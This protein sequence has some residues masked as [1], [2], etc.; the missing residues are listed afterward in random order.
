MAKLFQFTNNIDYNDIDNKPKIN[1]VTVEGNKSLADYGIQPA[2]NYAHLNANGKVPLEEID[3]SLLGNLQ[4]QGLWD[5]KTN[6]PELPLNPTINGQYWIVSESGDRFGTDFNVGDWIVA[7]NGVWRKVDNT[8]AV[9][10]VN[11][12]I[13]KVV[14]TS[15]DITHNDTTVSKAIDSEIN[16]AKESELLITSSLNNEIARAEA[17]EEEI[18][19]VLVDHIKDNNNPHNVTKEQIGLGEVDNTSD[20][21]KPISNAV[22]LALNLKADKT[23]VYTK[24][25]SDEK[26]LTE[27]QDISG[28]QDVI[29]DLD[30]IREGAK[31]GETALQSFTE[32]DPTVPEYVKSITQEDITNWNNKS[33]F[34]G[35]YN[36]LTN[37]PIIPDVSNFITKDVDNLTNYTKTSD[38]ATIATSGS[39]NDLS[40]KPYIPEEITESKVSEWGF[41]KNN[42]T[43]TSV[44]MNGKVI[45]SSG[46]VDLGTVITEHQDI[47]GKADKAT[48]LEGYGITNAYTKS[49]V[50]DLIPT[51]DGL[52]TEEYVKNYHDTTKQDKLIAGK[53]ITI[54]NN[55]ISA[56][57][58]SEPSITYTAGD[59]LT[60]SQE[61]EF[62]VNDTIA[63]T[64]K[65]NELLTTKQDT[66]TAGKDIAIENNVI[67]NTYDD[68]EILVNISDLQSDVQNLQTEI[69]KKANTTDVSNA[70]SMKQDTLIFDLVPTL[71]SEHPVYS[72]GIKEAIDVKQDV[73]RGS[74]GEIVYHNGNNVFTQT[75]MNES[76]VVTNEEELEKCKNNI[77]SFNEV[78]NKWIKF[79]H[80]N[81]N[82]NA[83][84]SEISAWVYDSTN[85]TI[86]QPLNTD[87]YVGFVS[88]NTYSN[89]D[90]T[91]RLYSTGGDNDTIGLVAAFAS[92]SSGKQ[93]TLSFLRSPG[94][95][96][97]KWMCKVDYCTFAMNLTSYN[98][99]TLVDKSSTSNGNS[100]NWNSTTIGTGSVVNIKRNGNVISGM[101]SQFNSNELD[102]N[103]LITI[104]LDELSATYP[105]LNNFKGSSS[106]GYGSFSQP[107][108]MYE[109]LSVTDSNGYILDI[110]NNNVLKYNSKTS[111][112]EEV[113]NLTP[114]NA[115]GIGRLS[116]NKITNKL[117]YNNG[118]LI[119]EIAKDTSAIDIAQNLTNPSE[120]TVPSTQA[121][122]NESARIM[123][124]VD[125]KQDI[126][127]AVNY[128]NISNCITEIPQDIKIE[129]N[130]GTL[131]LKDGSKVYIPNGFESDGTT[132][133]FDVKIIE[134]DL[135]VTFDNTIQ[136]GVLISPNNTIVHG[137]LS[138][139]FISSSTAPSISWGFWYDLT[140]NQIKWTNDGSTW[141]SGYSLPICIATGTNGSVT[142]IDQVFNGFGYIGSTIYALPGVKG[143]IPNGRNADGSLKNIE[144]T[145]DKVLTFNLSANNTY[146]PQILLFDSAL[147]IQGPTSIRTISY[148]ETENYTTYNNTNQSWLP[149]ITFIYNNNKITSFTPKTVFHAL[150]YNDKS[151]ISGWS[152][153]SS[154]YINLSVAASGSTYTAPANGYF[155]WYCYQNNNGYIF[156]QSSASLLPNRVANASN[157]IAGF[158]PVKKGDIVMVEYANLT[159]NRLRFIYAEGED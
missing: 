108:S 22:Q 82:D 139:H 126:S 133:K 15:E 125:T 117:F 141:I 100:A 41:T 101:C 85:D 143:L 72:K 140:N 118:S 90:I 75:L 92:D 49:E 1:N 42:G 27:H 150:D 34:S 57:G 3:D 83:I 6:S 152:M 156:V 147:N 67:S 114:I 16:R 94:G 68:T 113:V 145:V 91:V 84:P 52:A 124:A 88:P 54:E 19:N 109:N 61:N 111:V 121:I 71:N 53:N 7:T 28:K 112:W 131:T 103:T 96:S 32:T 78:F 74:N 154:R 76:M 39:Y 30:S 106:W 130:N 122:V 29:K 128:S 98:Q 158:I 63:R 87:S 40:D 55:V 10:S 44:K 89:Y 157:D 17:K 93:H 21:N 38:L 153:P 65:V 62:S 134:S 127:T 144:F 116:Y 58:S 12:K 4:F 107:N 146:E 142:S 45:S 47:N 23:E 43:I 36:D 31:L 14:L 99:I 60:L 120:N 25:E 138:D 66:L 8:D 13:G 70:L 105:V 77:P 18:K 79:S 9:I 5:A 151:T 86:R 37:K 97:G 104:D 20:I 123:S 56:T 102:E 155:S 129:L 115:M 149:I 159:F 132:K 135:T 110:L 26:F 69:V 35:N 11:G 148:N 95:T 50:N 136:K 64:N 2:G 119:Y 137:N 73:I 24:E 51:L 33:E 80:Q 48:T 81:G 59:G 46:E